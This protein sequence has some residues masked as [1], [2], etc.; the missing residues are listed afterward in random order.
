MISG[1]TIN[2][3]RTLIQ[4]ENPYYVEKLTL[5]KTYFK[6]TYNDANITS[7]NRRYA[8]CFYKRKNREKSTFLVF[9][10]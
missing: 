6:N 4:K 10:A 5:A 1:N 3:A 8:P 2:A 9:F 7:L